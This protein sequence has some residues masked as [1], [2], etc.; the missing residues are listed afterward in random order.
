[1]ADDLVTRCS[2][3]WAYNPIFSKGVESVHVVYF[4]EEHF[5]LVATNMGKTKLV[6]DEANLRNVADIR[7]S[8]MNEERHSDWDYSMHPPTVSEAMV[9][10]KFCYEMRSLYDEKMDLEAR[11]RRIS[12]ELSDAMNINPD[13]FHVPE[14]VTSG[15]KEAACGETKPETPAQ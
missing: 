11:S 4:P 14:S 3:R 1:M 10:R 9:P 15:N 5:A 2:I 13:I 12:V 6:T 7:A 8:I